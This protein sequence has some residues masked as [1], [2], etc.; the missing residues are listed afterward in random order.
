MF[1]LVLANATAAAD[2]YM[3]GVTV[4][5]ERGAAVESDE[6]LLARSV[7]DPLAF[8]PL[9][10]RHAAAVHAYLARRAPVVADDLLAEVWLAAFASRARFNPSLGTAR[11]WLFG[12]ARNTMLVHLRKPVASAL[13]AAD[14]PDEDGWDA[15]DDRLDAA[16]V[17][18]VLRLALAALPHVDR[19]LLLLVVWEQLSPTEAAQS[20]EIPAGTA[21]SRL[22]RAKTRLRESIEAPA[23]VT[24]TTQPIGER[25][26]S[27]S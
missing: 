22:H 18:P 6:D 10:G 24:T 12:V 20:L 11:G 16:A 25:K 17:A 13:N 23:H 21:R 5:Q 2:K 19:E 14:E 26:G 4:A 8:E 7:I 9:V 27:L 3:A 15:V 1:L